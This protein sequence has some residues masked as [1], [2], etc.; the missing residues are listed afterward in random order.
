MWKYESNLPRLP[1]PH[2]QDTARKYLEY[3]APLVSTQQ[4]E[5]TAKL[6]DEFINGEAK[7]L[8]EDLQRLDKESPTSWLEGFWDTM[9][10]TIRDPL[11]INVNPYFILNDDPLRTHQVNII[12]TLSQKTPFALLTLIKISG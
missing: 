1:V 4:L 3:V 2:L 11:P 9:Y 8:Q 12:N 5:H 10:L 6:V 7:A